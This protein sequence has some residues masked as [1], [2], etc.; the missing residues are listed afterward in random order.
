MI[1]SIKTVLYFPATGKNEW[2]WWLLSMM[3]A[4]HQLFSSHT[5]KRGITAALLSPL[6]TQHTDQH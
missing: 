4:R 2:I 3:Y 5:I 1:R 6:L